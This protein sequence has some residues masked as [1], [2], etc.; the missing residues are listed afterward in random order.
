[1][2]EWRLY[3]ATWHEWSK[4]VSDILID[5]KV[6]LNNKNNVFVLLSKNDIVWVIGYVMSEKFKIT[7]TS[8]KFYRVENSK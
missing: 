7:K 4:K 2:D 6:N 3:T 8:K 1:M 5:K